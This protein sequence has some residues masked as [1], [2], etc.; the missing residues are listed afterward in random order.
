M[1]SFSKLPT[2]LILEVVQQ[3]PDIQSLLNVMQASLVVSS[4]FDDYA[5]EITTALISSIFSDQLDT[6]FCKAGI[7]R[8]KKL[9]PYQELLNFYIYGNAS[10]L[11]LPQESS[12]LL[13][14]LHL[15]CNVQEL[16]HLCLKELLDRAR[17][18]PFTYC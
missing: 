8:S 17:N 15:A 9:P 3:L 6:L 18:D 5:V 10:E 2:E 12:V 1:D 11:Q 13:S 14:L 7:V 4:F 16:A